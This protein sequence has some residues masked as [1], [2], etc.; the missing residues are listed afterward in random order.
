MDALLRGICY[1]K[2]TNGG[3]T[4]EIFIEDHEPIGL[5]LW[6]RLKEARLVKIVDGRIFLTELGEARWRDK[7]TTGLTK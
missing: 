1:I 4:V 6:N 7:C 5:H 3:A 2:N